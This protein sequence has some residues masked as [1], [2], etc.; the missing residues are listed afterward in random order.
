MHIRVSW[1][2]PNERSRQSHLN[3]RSVFCLTEQGSS[4]YWYGVL[5]RPPLLGVLGTLV[6]PNPAWDSG[7]ALDL[8]A[9]NISSP[10]ISRDLH[11]SFPSSILRNSVTHRELFQDAV[12]QEAVAIRKLQWNICMIFVII[13]FLKPR[14]EHGSHSA[15]LSLTKYE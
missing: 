1:Y 2:I 14:S 10:P 6:L 15:G 11:H 4:R 7:P 5:V 13:V 3:Q 8:A 12:P 9:E